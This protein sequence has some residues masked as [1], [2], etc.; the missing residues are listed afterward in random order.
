M[1]ILAQFSVAA[2]Q[3]PLPVAEPWTSTKAFLWQYEQLL[4]VLLSVRSPF[5]VGSMR[6]QV[7]K[8]MKSSTRIYSPTRATP[9]AWY[10]IANP[11]DPVTESHDPRP[12]QAIDLAP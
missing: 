6:P 12:T 2:V 10:T 9:A 5:G 8:E 7:P 1:G 4:Y 3:V 11:V